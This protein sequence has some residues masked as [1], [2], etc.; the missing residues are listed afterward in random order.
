MPEIDFIVND[1]V[2][3]LNQDLL[4][5]TVECIPNHKE[6]QSLVN[7]L[8]A[9]DNKDVLTELSA[10]LDLD[11]DTFDTLW[12]K[13]DTDIKYNL[14][15]STLHAGKLAFF[16]SDEKIKDIIA[17]NDT[18]TLCLL[19]YAMSDLLHPEPG[20]QDFT[21]HTR[22]SKAAI[23]QLVDHLKASGNKSITR[24][25]KVSIRKKKAH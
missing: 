24:I 5:L 8:I 18:E 2:F 3:P 16:L 22:Y 15:Y 23:S 12:Q 11:C 10:K 7:E 25:L 21:C 20:S 4:R 14:L 17:D 1:K 13:G 9:L 19:S 6:Y